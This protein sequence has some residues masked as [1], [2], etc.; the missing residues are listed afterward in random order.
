MPTRGS[1][2][3]NRYLTFTDRLAAVLALGVAG[4][5]AAFAPTGEGRCEPGDIVSYS[6]D[7]ID[8]PWRIVSEFETGRFVIR[9]GKVKAI[10]DANQIEPY[11]GVS[12]HVTIEMAGDCWE[13]KVQEIRQQHSQQLVAETQLPAMAQATAGQ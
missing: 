8:R 1:R 12:P 9:N 2:C 3:A 13:D 10:A 11:G 4:L 7:H 6:E 5:A